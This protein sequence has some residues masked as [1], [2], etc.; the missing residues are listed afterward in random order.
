MKYD[1]TYKTIRAFECNLDKYQY[2]V[3]NKI[4]CE[5]YYKIHCELYC[6]L[7]D[8][9]KINIINNELQMHLTQQ[10]EIRE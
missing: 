5:L 7:I 9:L 8:E 10:V 3:F 6:F 1:K 4:H 2:V